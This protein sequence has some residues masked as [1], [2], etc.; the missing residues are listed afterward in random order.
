LTH[1]VFDHHFSA[2]E[3]AKNMFDNYQ[4]GKM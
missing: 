4:D 3:Y 1:K 2:K